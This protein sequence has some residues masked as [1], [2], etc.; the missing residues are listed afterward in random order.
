MACRGYL[1][2][3]RYGAV[4]KAMRGEGRASSSSSS[5]GETPL[6]TTTTT[7]TATSSVHTPA[8]TTPRP[9]RASFGGS[10]ATPGTRSFDPRSGRNS[11]GGGGAAGRGRRGSAGTGRGVR[12]GSGGRGGG[13]SGGNGG[14]GKGGGGSASRGGGEV[15]GAAVVVV[16]TA[17]EVLTRSVR[18][19][20]YNWS[21]WLDLAGLCLEADTVSLWVSF[22]FA[23]T[24]IRDS[25]NGNGT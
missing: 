9:T 19:Y 22:L 24:M 8:P 25:C 6:P 11:I 12:G 7:T 4:L 3:R 1:L 17:E 16:A 13:G 10:R 5:L 18:L 21:A 14:G 15:K 20:P 23:H 2:C